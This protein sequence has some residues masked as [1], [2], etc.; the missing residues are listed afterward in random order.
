MSSLEISELLRGKT[1]EELQIF[2]KK[3]KKRCRKEFTIKYGWPLYNNT[4]GLTNKILFFP[5]LINEKNKVLKTEKFCVLNKNLKNS[6]FAFLTSTEISKLIPSVKNKKMVSYL[7]D[8]L[9]E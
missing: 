3:K 7:M 9:S 2:L 5:V 4:D 8:S 6:I 1:R